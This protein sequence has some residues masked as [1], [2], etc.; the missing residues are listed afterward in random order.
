[1][2][3]QDNDLLSHC[4]LAKVWEDIHPYDV[5]HDAEDETSF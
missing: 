5:V 2:I 4:V 3:I 1:L